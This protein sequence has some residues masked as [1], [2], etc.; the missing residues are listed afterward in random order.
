MKKKNIQF[1]VTIIGFVIYFLFSI[2]ISTYF[3]GKAHL[4]SLAS[5][6]GVMVFAIGIFM[7]DIFK[8]KKIKIE[9]EII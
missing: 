6:F 3:G 9:G 5:N 2:I 1:L 8:F 7:D 4:C